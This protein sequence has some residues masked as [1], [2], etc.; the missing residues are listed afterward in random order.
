MAKKSIKSITVSELCEAAEI[1][2][3]TFYNHYGCP[4][5]VLKEIEVGVVDDLNKI[6]EECGIGKN[7]PI[8]KRVE[9]LCSYL[10]EH[11]DVSRLL[12]RDSYT[13][14]EFATML[15]Q[16]TYIKATYDQVL[17]YAECSDGKRLIITF[18]TNGTY[19]MIRQ[20]LLEDI[21]LTPKE[22][23]D[24]IFVIAAKGWERMYQ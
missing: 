11:K 12:F 8:N 13:G 4:N 9:A 21:P 20:W 10:L 24:L 7:W 23:G 16:A 15:F 19:H 5:D 17:S 3:S 22:I 14:S 2:R 6:W 18:I 1:N